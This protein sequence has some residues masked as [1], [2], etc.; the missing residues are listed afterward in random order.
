MVQSNYSSRLG[1]Q[2]PV[3]CQIDPCTEPNYHYE[4]ILINVSI[5][6]YYIIQSS[7]TLNMTGYLY[8]TIF[9]P[10]YVEA[11]LLDTDDDNAGNNQFRFI[12]YLQSTSEYI[13]VVTTQGQN[14][15]GKYTVIVTGYI[16]VNFSDE[17]VVGNYFQFYRLLPIF[18]FANAR[19]Q[20]FDHF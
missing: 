9:N 19:I 15:V 16:T 1:K 13:L 17:Y 5:S 3:Y 4:P 10:L 18:A 2:T 14:T 6:G 20:L 8:K 11:Y 7:S 12:V